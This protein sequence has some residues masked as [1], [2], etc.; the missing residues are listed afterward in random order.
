MS[1]P[2]DDSTVHVDAAGAAAAID[3]VVVTHES[4]DSID[5]CLARLR[6]ADGVATIRVVDNASRDET[7]AIV[8]RHALADARLRFIANP[9][10]PGFGSACNQGAAG[11]H[12]PWIALVNPDCL[13]ARD[14]LARIA[15]HARG[16]ATQMLLG[17]DMIDA[18]GTRDPAARRRAPDFAAM[19][20]DPSTRHLAIAVAPS[21]TLQPV[22]AISGALMLLPRPLFDALGGFDT[23]YRLHAEDLDLCLRARQAGA[24][25]AVAN[26]VRVV[27]LR[28]VSS[29]ARPLF[30]E[31]HRHRGLARY[32]RLHEAPRRGIATRLAVYAAIWLRFLF[33]APRS[34]LR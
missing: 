9:D 5:D 15:A 27:H 7:V 31:W 32:F 30:V 21:R 19:L 34:L 13:P 28:G 17:A 10:N 26:D 2:A 25:V 20:R 23:G 16:S 14:A 3:V 24:Q 29:R 11:G 12:A 1:T 18:D 8:Q 33:A 22:D 4:A 6:A